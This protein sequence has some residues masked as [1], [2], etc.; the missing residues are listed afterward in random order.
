MNHQ[1]SYAT[2]WRKDRSAVEQFDISADTLVDYATQ[3]LSQGYRL[4][5]VAAHDL[6]DSAR[7]VYLFLG[8][9]VDER[10]ELHVVTPYQQSVPSLAHISFSANRFER[11]IRDL[12]GITFAGHHNPRRLVFHEQWP[13]G[14]HP[15]REV[16]TTRPT[17]RDDAE[18]ESLVPV[19]GPGVYEIPVGPVHAGLIEPGHF[20]FTVV[21]ETILTMKSRLWYLHRGI[22]RLFHGRLPQDGISLA[23]RV[24][25]DSAV[26]H[27]LSFCRAVEDAMGISVSLEAEILRAIAL[28]CERIY[29]HIGDIGML[30]NDVAFGFVNAHA[31]RLKEQCLRMNADLTGHRLL[32]NSV[33]V[34]GAHLRSLPERSHLHTIRDEVRDLRDIAL[35]NTTVVDRF[36]GTGVLHRDAAL[37]LG[38]LGYVARA[39]GVE[40][41]ARHVCGPSAIYQS[42]SSPHHHTGDVMARFLVRVDE[43]IASLELIESLLAHDIALDQRPHI[44]DLTQSMQGPT[45]GVGICE[46]WRGSVVHRVEL[47][48]AGRFTRTKI[49]DPSFFNWPALPEALHDTIVPDFPLVNK[50]FNLS[51]AGNDL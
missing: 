13:I 18:P 41:D 6:G 48:H 11:E 28:E 46:G 33:V 3:Y 2:N 37:A 15:M 49:V 30:C 39:S 36:R 20:R 1:E 29:N 45:S 24:S 27:S 9:V 10:T 35:G 43:V 34:G 25:G 19:V 50:S 23:E 42:L 26:A 16:H 8:N 51:Y 7:L 4:A 44:I 31:A 40:R 32:R 38:T 17:M 12:Y 5:L 22:E 47:D 21:G 14:W